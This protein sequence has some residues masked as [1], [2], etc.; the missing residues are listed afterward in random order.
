MRLAAGL[1]SFWNERGYFQEGRQWLEAG[2]AQR[3]HLPKDLLAQTLRAAGR[4]AGRQ[5][6]FDRAEAYAQES[7]SLW[8][9]LGDKANLARALNTLAAVCSERGDVAGSVAYNE[10]AL[11]LNRELN[12]QWGVAQA[13]SDVGWSAVFLGDVA[14]GTP[15]LEE[16]LA[17]QRQLQDTFGIAWSALALGVAR[18]LQGESDPAAALLSESLRLFGA[19]HN[20]WY[21]AG[22]L[23]IIAAIASARQ[24]YQRA[25]QLLGAHDRLVEAMG[26]KIPLFWERAIRQPLLAQLN[27]AIDETTFTA[28][29]S[30]GQALT[31]EQALEY[32]LNTN[33]EQ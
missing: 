25:A 3:G 19:L 14:R 10:E 33:E 4:L 23:E 24:R 21:I 12:D 7:V 31:F 29:W 16:S 18:F 22:C 27:T 32:A 28:A 20:H 30:A 15:L 17:L 5:G 8:R 2:L 9:E 6:D 26:A 11:Q 13:L 1:G